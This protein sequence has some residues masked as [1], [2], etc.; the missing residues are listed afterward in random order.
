MRVNPEILIVDDVINAAKDFG[1]LIVSK[2][3]FNIIT[4]GNPEEAIELVKTNNIKVVVLDQKMPLMKGTD[5]YKK[6]VQINPFIKAVMFSG[7]ASREEVSDA[8]EFGYDS[9][10]DKTKIALLPDKVF[11][12]YLKFEIDFSKQFLMKDC[13]VIMTEKS[14]GFNRHVV[15][16]Y[17]L[18]I[19]KLNDNFVFQDKWNASLEIHA[20]QNLEV[21][22]IISFEETITV[23][24][25][26][27][28]KIKTEFSLSDKQLNVLKLNF[29]N[30][31]NQK[32]SYSTSNKNTH[33]KRKK[34]NYSLPS[35]PADLNEN[36]IVKRTIEYT[37]I[38][39]EYRA[40]ICKRCSFC[41]KLEIMP[42]IFYKQSN[43]ISYRQINILKDQSKEIIDMGNTQYS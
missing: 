7:E 10:L 21:E 22:E 30:E 29:S 40:T 36:Y 32:Y 23:N 39:A 25:D 43:R 2:F 35:Q 37:P 41:N 9:F 26:F 5:L 31:I 1:E 38:Y 11:E 14:W 34:V 24:Q 6:L 12:A 3:P 17:I 15:N 42:I 33:Q 28:Q 8:F 4:T 16:F 19:A 13:P 18:N 20:G 27:E